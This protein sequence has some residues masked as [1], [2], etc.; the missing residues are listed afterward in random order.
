MSDCSISAASRAHSFPPTSLKAQF[1]GNDGVVFP[2]GRN[3]TKK[4][5]SQPRGKGSMRRWTTYQ[6]ELEEGR[7]SP[8]VVTRCQARFFV[9]SRIQGE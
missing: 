8:A 5:S 2:W 9:L 4:K 7:I 3:H 6:L 1:M